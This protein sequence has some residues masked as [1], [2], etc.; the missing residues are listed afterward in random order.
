MRLNVKDRIYIPQLM[1]QSN[2]FLDFNLKRGIVNKASLNED[3][4]EKYEIKEDKENGR[5]TWNPTKDAEMPIEVEFTKEELKFLKDACEKLADAPYPD[6][7]WVM[8][9]KIYDEANKNE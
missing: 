4:V 1:P 9:E 7:F 3:D 2:N 5:I 8:V 6:D